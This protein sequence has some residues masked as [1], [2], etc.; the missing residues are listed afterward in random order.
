MNA[1]SKKRRPALFSIVIL[2]I[3]ATYFSYARGAWLAV[4][5]GIITFWLI[6]KRLVVY[7]YVLCI[8]IMLSTVFWLKK[9]DRYIKYAHNYNTTIFHSNFQ[10]HLTA[11]YH[12]KDVSTAERFYRWIAGVRMVKDYWQTGTGP[13][14]FYPA[15][16]GYTIG[17][18]KTWV[19]RNDDHSTVHNYFLLTL[20]EQG[21]LGLLLLLILIGYLF[22]TA[23][24]IYWHTNDIFWKRTVVVVAVIL[25]MV[26]TVNFLSDLIETDKIGSVFY[27]CIAVLIIAES[28]TIVLNSSANIE[29]IPQ[30]I[31]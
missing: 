1:I 3:T 22:Y 28:K 4:C 19:S 26:C 11:T 29:G 24:R 31:S 9:D 23:Q 12:L 27:L 20:I 16:M 30:P 5:I 10:E 13:G 15:Y 18:F 14:T 21:V 7:A 17:A 8:L 2:L 25:S 6:K